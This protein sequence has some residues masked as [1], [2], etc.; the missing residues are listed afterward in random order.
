MCFVAHMFQPCAFPHLLDALVIDRR[1]TKPL[2]C[3]SCAMLSLQK[4]LFDLLDDFFSRTKW[5]S[6]NHYISVSD[7]DNNEVSDTKL[8]AVIQSYEKQVSF[9]IL[10]SRN[11]DSSQIS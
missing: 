7:V 9:M 1:Q 2:T 8:T 3:T 11:I 6:L 10:A 4:S 5:I